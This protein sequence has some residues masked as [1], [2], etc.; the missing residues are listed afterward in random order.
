MA[1]AG[2]E[3]GRRTFGSAILSI[4]MQLIG[5]EKPQTE[6]VNTKHLVARTLEAR[7]ASMQFIVL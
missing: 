1:G 4:C 2:K 3:F 5:Q 6:N 7:K